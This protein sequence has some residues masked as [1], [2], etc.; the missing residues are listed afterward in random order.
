MTIEQA[1]NPTNSLTCI[2]RFMTYVLKHLGGGLNHW[3][4][5]VEHAFTGLCKGRDGADRL[6]QFVRNSTR[7]FFQCREPCNLK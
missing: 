4:G 3:F 1:A 5:P 6:I 7:H 2:E